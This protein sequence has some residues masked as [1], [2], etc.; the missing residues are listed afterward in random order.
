M[1]FW[2]LPATLLTLTLPVR[3]QPPEAHP[4]A[5]VKRTPPK[6]GLAPKMKVTEF[7]RT[8]R[9]F[10]LVFGKGDD[11]H[12][13]LNDFAIKQH[14]TVA[15]F[16]AVGALDHAV[17]GWSDPKVHAFKTTVLDQEVEVVAFSGSITMT[18][19]KPNVHVHAVVAL[20][21]GTTRGGDLIE[22]R[23]SLT[24][25]LFLDDAEPAPSTDA[26]KSQ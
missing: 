24:L 4:D 15:H 20:P 19:G 13:G 5:L 6:E 7:A 23:V 16:T 25:Q 11:V 8:G 9:S 3:A 21:D 17:L 12:S 14:L 22:G 26:S 2:L 1:R 10:E 18:N